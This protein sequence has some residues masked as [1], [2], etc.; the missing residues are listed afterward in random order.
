M[1]QESNI[2][3][4]KTHL[5]ALKSSSSAYGG[6]E[7]AKQDAEIYSLKQASMI[8]SSRSRQLRSFHAPIPG[9]KRFCLNL[10]QLEY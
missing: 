4:K 3:H 2:E 7:G 10:Q 6:F 9:M 8:N 5:Q 1:T